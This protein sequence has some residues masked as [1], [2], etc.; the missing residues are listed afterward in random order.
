MAK[1]YQNTSWR[2]CLPQIIKSGK[3]LGI[4][5]CDLAKRF[6]LNKK[7]LIISGTTDS[8]A[9]FLAAGLDKEEVLQF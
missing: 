4:I 1:G 6:Q 2:K 9:A 3:I 5:D 8:N 7:I